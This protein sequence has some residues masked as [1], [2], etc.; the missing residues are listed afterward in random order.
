MPS[1]SKVFCFLFFFTVLKQSPQI[2]SNAQA[3]KFSFLLP[4][5][6]QVKSV[7]EANSKGDVP[8]V[9]DAGSSPPRPTLEVRPRPRTCSHPRMF[10]LPFVSSGCL[11]PENKQQ[12][13]ELPLKPLSILPWNAGVPNSALSI[14][15]NTVWPFKRELQLAPSSQ[16]TSGI[17]H[18][19]RLLPGYK[20]RSGRD[21]G[22]PLPEPGLR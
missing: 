3:P 4:C 17:S 6:R 16:A 7:V 9:G 1:Y 20:I 10:P 13:V 2:A 8:S 14:P 15:N 5:V 22:V 12:E 21:P 11:D 19:P 18:E